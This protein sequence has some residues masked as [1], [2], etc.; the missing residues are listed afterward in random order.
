MSLHSVLRRLGCHR[1]NIF[2]V[3]LELTFLVHS[4]SIYEDV[5]GKKLLYYIS[6][7]ISLCNTFI[8]CGPIHSVVNCF[9]V[10]TIWITTFGNLCFDKRNLLGKNSYSIKTIR[11]KLQFSKNLLAEFVSFFKKNLKLAW[12]AP[13]T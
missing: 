9:N 4:S 5:Y 6:R 12:F 8:F 7:A 1:F 13:F 11:K 10:S 2:P 3:F